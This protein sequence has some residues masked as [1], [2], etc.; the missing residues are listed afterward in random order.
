MLEFR[1]NSSGLGIIGPACLKLRIISK[2]VDD[3]ERIQ[4]VKGLRIRVKCLRITEIW[5]FGK[6][7]TDYVWIIIYCL[8]FCLRIGDP[9]PAFRWFKLWKKK[10][11]LKALKADTEEVERMLKA[12]IKSLE[13]KR[14]DPWPL[15]SFQ[16]HQL[17]WRWTYLLLLNRNVFMANTLVVCFEPAIFF[18]PGKG[19]LD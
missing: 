5:K 17:F 2:R 1:S 18:V 19:Q 6:S 9:G 15:E 16:N 11:N 12:L 3:F 10:E 14:L 8:G 7:H 4:G 13:N